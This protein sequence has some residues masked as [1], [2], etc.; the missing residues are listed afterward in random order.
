MTRRHVALVHS[1]VVLAAFLVAAC[2]PAPSVEADAPRSPADC[3]AL[4]DETV[5]V[6]VTGFRSTVDEPVEGSVRLEYA[7]RHACPYAGAVAWSGCHRDAYAKF[8][9][10]S[11]HG[12]C[13]DRADYIESAIFA[14]CFRPIALPVAQWNA[15]TRECVGWAEAGAEERRAAC[16]PPSR[17]REARAPREPRP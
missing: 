6:C 16:R 8:A 11:A 9:G 14:S 5:L 4:R 17:D 15:L 2:V 10:R 12:P 7:V 1:A 13:G 3:E